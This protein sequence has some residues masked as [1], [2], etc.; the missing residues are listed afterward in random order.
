MFR[1]AV[2]AD[3]DLEQLPR[4][5]L[6]ARIA[7]LAT[8]TFTLPG[9]QQVGFTERTLWSWWSAYKRA[10][11]LGLVPKERKDRGVAKVIDRALLD[12]A[13]AARNEIPSRSTSTVID[14]LEKQRLVPPGKLRRSTLDRHLD[15]AGASRRRLKT[16]GDKRFIRMLFERP[17][18]FWVGDYHDAPL[19]FDRK[20][21][22]FREVHLC[23]WIDHYSKLVP[24]AQWYTRENL[25]T[26]EDAFKKAILKRGV[27]ESNY[28]DNA[29][30]YHSHDFA[31]A[32]AHLGIK[33][34]HSKKHTSE[35]RGVIERWNRTIVD[36]FE[37]E[38]MAMQIDDLDVLN[39]VFEGWLEQR[40]HLVLHSATGQAPADRFAMTGFQPSFPDPVLVQDTFRVRAR[41]KVHPKTCT[42]EVEGVAFVVETFLRGRWVSVHYDPHRLDDV[43]VFSDRRRIQRAFRQ[44]PNEPPLPRPEQPRASPPSFNYLGALRAEYDKRLVAEARKLSLSDWTPT[45]SFA[46]PAFLALCASML[47][48]DLSSYDRDE[49]TLA[50]NTV[51]PLSE[52]TCRLALEHALKLRGRGLH[53]SVYSHYL[54]VFHLEAIKALKPSR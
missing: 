44:Q 34:R 36:Q 23:A 7:A 26:L 12:A 51:G 2:I 1:Y 22:R 31:F 17:N 24:H 18:Q 20:T 3:L 37:P 45:D 11:L 49:L 16:L 14:V 13:I 43:L 19:L 8:R 42:V 39:R 10:G 40:Y 5:E 47:G 25:A 33:S 32:L 29:R 15:H 6:S 46:L 52:S 4:G 9:G 50:F 41:R 35:G 38:A 48:K 28:V 21:Q 27:P 54:K 53:V 30:I